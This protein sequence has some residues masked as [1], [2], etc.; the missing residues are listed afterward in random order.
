MSFASDM[1]GRYIS[2]IHIF[3]TILPIT[4]ITS[5]SGFTNIKVVIQCRIRTDTSNNRTKV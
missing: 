5:S 1:E 2:Y 4:L 3:V